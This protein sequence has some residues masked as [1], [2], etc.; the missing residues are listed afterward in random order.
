MKSDP[1][2]QTKAWP[3]YATLKH[4]D[5]KVSGIATIPS[6]RM[7]APLRTNCFSLRRQGVHPELHPLPGVAL[8][9]HPRPVIGIRL[10]RPVVLVQFW[11]HQQDAG[12]SADHVRDVP[13]LLLAK[14]SPQ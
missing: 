13:R 9:S 10:D 6:P 2:P 5:R 3:W 7:R 14:G 11:L 1:V 12:D 4:K 8:R